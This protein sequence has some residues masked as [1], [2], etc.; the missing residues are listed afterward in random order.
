MRFAANNLGIIHWFVDASY[1]IHN[2]CKGHTGSMLTME[3]GAVISF[4][5][6]QKLNAKSST[7]AELIRVNDA[8]SQILWTRYFMESGK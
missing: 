4:S 1:A 7:G 5:R 3:A 2:D 8:L 6:K